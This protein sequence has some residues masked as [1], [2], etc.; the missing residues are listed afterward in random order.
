[1]VCDGKRPSKEPPSRD[2]V[3]VGTRLLWVTDGSGEGMVPDDRLDGM[4]HRSGTLGGWPYSVRDLDSPRKDVSAQRQRDRRIEE[5]KGSI[6]AWNGD[7]ANGFTGTD[8]LSDDVFV[9]H[10]TPPRCLLPTD[11]MWT[12][13]TLGWGRLDGGPVLKTGEGPV[14]MRDS[15]EVSPELSLSVPATGGSR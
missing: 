14:S 5:V 4:G 8:E 1:M 11:V 7:G 15:A 3:D 12:I 9:H 13:G 2:C 6:T 10:V